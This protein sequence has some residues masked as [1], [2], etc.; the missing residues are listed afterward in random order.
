[1][2]VRDVRKGVASLATLAVIVLARDQPEK[3]RY[4]LMFW[5]AVQ[6]PN[7]DSGLFSGKVEQRRRQVLVGLPR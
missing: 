7:E 2:A 6:F 1:M 3:A 4:R 5:A